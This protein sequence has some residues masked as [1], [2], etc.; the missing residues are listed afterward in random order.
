MVEEPLWGRA[1]WFST[2]GRN[3][4]TASADVTVGPREE[5]EVLG[6]ELLIGRVQVALEARHIRN[7]DINPTTESKF[8]IKRFQ[9]HLEVAEMLQHADQDQHVN[10]GTIVQQLMQGAYPDF[11]AVEPLR[12][13]GTGG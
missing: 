3:P 10:R 12:G 7:L 4:A 11:N 9:R 8:L 5:Q 13:R 6:R 2:R 1:S